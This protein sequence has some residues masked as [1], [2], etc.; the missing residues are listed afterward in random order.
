MATDPSQVY[1][2]YTPFSPVGGNP[3]SLAFGQYFLPP[4][5]GAQAA[6][7]PQTAGTLGNTGSGSVQSLAPYSQSAW[8]QFLPF[9]IQALMGNSQQ[10]SSSVF[11]VGNAL[12][13]T[14]PTATPPIA[15]PFGGTAYV[16][17]P[18][19]GGAGGGGGMTPGGGGGGGGAWAGPGFEGSVPGTAA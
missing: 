12:F 5:F 4:S 2:P 11:P 15:T 17:S 16:T 9:I 14:Q 8:Y 3:S 19:G 18:E 13:S 6:S 1:N 10:P 7:S